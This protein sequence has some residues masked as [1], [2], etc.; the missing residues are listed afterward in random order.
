MSISATGGFTPSG[1]QISA[2]P[3]NVPIPAGLM[4][5]LNGWNRMDYAKQSLLCAIQPLNL[6]GQEASIQC[7]EENAKDYMLAG[8]IQEHLLRT[9]LLIRV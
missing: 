9:L 5:H 6:A 8:K 1:L 4:A 3:A 2:G 7:M